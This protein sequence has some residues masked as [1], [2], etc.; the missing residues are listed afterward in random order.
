MQN[1]CAIDSNYVIDMC[2]CQ[3]LRLSPLHHGYL[4]SCLP[5]DSQPVSSVMQLTTLR[6]AG[7][8]SEEAVECTW[9][10]PAGV[11]TSHRTP[12]MM[13]G[14]ILGGFAPTH[15]HAWLRSGVTFTPLT[16]DGHL[17]WT[18]P[19]LLARQCWAGIS[20]LCLVRQK[21]L[22]SDIQLG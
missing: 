17:C 7:R 21:M 3:A 11:H 2:V 13:Y 5:A 4:I 14:F 8:I 20:H 19:A 22:Q 16:H 12:Y 9:R 15:F 1:A 10:R 6:P 18:G